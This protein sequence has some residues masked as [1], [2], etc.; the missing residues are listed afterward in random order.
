MEIVAIAGG[1]ALRGRLRAEVETFEAQAKVSKSEAQTG[2]I[3]PRPE[4]PPADLS[5]VAVVP[6]PNH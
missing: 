2:K 6:V 3:G 4:R 5:T 1:V